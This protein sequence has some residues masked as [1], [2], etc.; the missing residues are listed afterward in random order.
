MTNKQKAARFTAGATT[1]EGI[2]FQRYAA[3][4]HNT[5]NCQEADIG[6]DS[7]ANNAVLRN[8]EVLD[9]AFIGV[10]TA[11]NNGVTL[12]NVTV[13]G[14]NWMGVSATL[15][16]N[17][18]LDAIISN[19]H[20]SFQ[21]FT[22]SPQSGGLKTSRTWYT[23]V[24]NS[25]VSNN[26]SHGIWF[27]QSNY[28]IEVVNT[29]VT[30]NTGAGIFFE[31][32]DDFLLANSYI[33]NN[34]GD[35]AVKLAGSSGL[36]LVNN[37]IVGSSKDLVG[38]YID[39]RS[40]PGCATDASK[41]FNTDTYS[42]DRGAPAGLSMPATMN[43]MPS[44]DLW[45]NNII[46]YPNA[47][48]SGGGYCGGITAVCAMLSRAEATVAVEYTFHKADSLRPQ[49]VMENNVYVNTANAN[50][51]FRMKTTSGTPVY[52]LPQLTSYFASAPVNIP[53]L[54]DTSLS[55]TNWFTS[56]GTPTAALAAK[57]G[58]AYAVPTTITSK[59]PALATKHYGVLWK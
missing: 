31:I 5:G 32:S 2:R 45:A 55:G 54:E 1:I 51:I 11:N 59:Y 9:S 36:K 12:K 30:N 42:S 41:C 43:W 16:Q 44:V 37:T 50:A 47:G 33:A 46:G 19:N 35:A 15:T 6:F 34:G 40:Q 18:T 4:L 14:A 57:H 29:T 23:K 24:I 27:D 25:D 3:C 7:G 22:S 26:K 10:K 13:R 8:V 56:D 48:T 20:N 39:A 53:G 21:E 17:V 49:T 58:E 52:T 28:K 38:I